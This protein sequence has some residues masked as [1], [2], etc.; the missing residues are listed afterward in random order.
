M[1]GSDICGG[2][3]GIVIGGGYRR[4]ID[5]LLVVV[6]VLTDEY[7]LSLFIAIDCVDG[8]V[9]RIFS[10]CDTVDVLRWWRWICCVGGVSID[11]FVGLN[12]VILA[13]TSF[14]IIVGDEHGLTDGVLLAE[15]VLLLNLEMK[16]FN[17]WRLDF[18]FIT[19]YLNKVVVE[20]LLVNLQLIDWR[21]SVD[22]HLDLDFVQH[23]FHLNDDDQHVFVVHPLK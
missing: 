8:C 1:I 15:I 10:F 11:V 13:K 2:G 20:V 4:D 7:D 16:N 17:F 18:E 3:E 5:P 14:F 22:M 19:Q 23:L 6:S 12:A 21:Y 9:V